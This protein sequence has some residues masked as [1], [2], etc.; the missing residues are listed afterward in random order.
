[1]RIFISRIFPANIISLWYHIFSRM[2]CCLTVIVYLLRCGNIS[3]SSQ[4]LCSGYDNHV[5]TI[6]EKKNIVIEVAKK[7]NNSKEEKISQIS[8]TD[9][10][11]SQ[12]NN[13]VKQVEDLID[14]LQIATKKEIKDVPNK[15]IRELLHLLGLLLVRFQGQIK[16]L[17]N[18][19]KTQLF[20]TIANE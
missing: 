15:R 13:I 11:L 3:K 9:I 7:S 16:D 2:F 6:I 12:V 10:T 8:H 19:C 20:V 5:K 17:F 1:M 18:I 14:T 4:Y